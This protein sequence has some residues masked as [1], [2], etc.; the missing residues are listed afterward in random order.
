MVGHSHGTFVHGG[1]V[2]AGA[3]D[4]PSVSPWPPA[5]IGGSC[6]TSTCDYAWQREYRIFN[7]SEL[8]RI[9]AAGA[10]SHLLHSHILRQHLLVQWAM[11]VVPMRVQ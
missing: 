11:V 9:C 4:G 2:G 6:M 8:T 3:A 5:T 1:T 10:M 7:L